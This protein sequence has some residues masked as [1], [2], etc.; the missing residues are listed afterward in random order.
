[1]DAAAAK[2]R[3][4]RE[5]IPAL[6]DR[7]YLNTGTSGPVPLDVYEA[8]VELLRRFSYEGY[9]TPDVAAAYAQALHAARKAVAGLLHCDVSE[10]VLTHSTTDAIGIVAHGLEWQ[11][12]DEVI[13]SD[14]E[15]SSGIAPWLHLARLYGVRVVYLRSEDGHLPAEAYARAITERTK[16][17]CVSHVSWATGTV[18]PVREICRLA[19]DAGVL[20]LIDGAQS[21][22]HIPVDL[23]TVDC[24]FYAVPGQ[25]WLLGPEGTGA[26]FVRRRALD[27]LNP[28]RIGWSSLADFDPEAQ[29]LAYHPD[30]R[31]FEGGTVHAPAFAG[32]AK[33]VGILQNVGL[34]AVFAQAVR[35]AGLARERLAALPHVHILSPAATPS[36]L[37]TFTVAGTDPDQCVR[38]LW[39]EHRVI[40]RSIPPL[41]ALRASFHAFNTEEDVEALVRGVAL[42]R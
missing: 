38:R 37:L 23:G 39:Q 29:T 9:S 41:G 31:R 26:L 30:A 33:A 4:L 19:R 11:P 5:Q 40:V 13:T 6:S 15:H 28:T 3:S 8:E 34:E 42:L 16:L 21:A 35:L 18:L 20:T 24:D 10:V 2:L 27:R 22:G 36:G 1:M 7:V 17:I 32:L 14:L 25:K 12:G